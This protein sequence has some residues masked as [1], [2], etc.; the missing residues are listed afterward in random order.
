M[1][2]NIYIFFKLYSSIPAET[3]SQNRHQG[4]DNY[5]M[6]YP[7]S[8]YNGSGPTM[9]HHMWKVARPEGVVRERQSYRPY[10]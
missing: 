8:Y 10:P 2:L 4:Y 3:H 1:K 7:N 9:Y 5:G 6:F